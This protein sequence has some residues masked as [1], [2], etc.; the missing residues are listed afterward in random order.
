MN[1]SDSQS[2]VPCV[3]DSQPSVPRVVPCVADSQPSVPRVTGAV[4][5]L[6]SG[7]VVSYF[8]RHATKTHKN[9]TKCEY[10]LDADLTPEGE[11]EARE[12]AEELKRAGVKI[13]A[14]A[15]SPYLR[16]RRTAVI[17]AEVLGVEKVTVNNLLAECLCRQK[18]V[19]KC[20][21]RESTFEYFTPRIETTKQY[22]TRMFRLMKSAS[23]QKRTV[24]YVTHGYNIYTLSLRQM[25]KQESIPVARHDARD[26][27]NIAPG[28]YVELYF[29]R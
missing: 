7:G 2:V 28:A 14:V 13:D 21:V 9:N 10:R 3:A 6:H 8:A 25:K 1:T 17:Y 22:K 4:A 24:L 20:D 11:R 19:N 26:P 15:S 5:A 23:R 18:Y 29:A 16:A 12:Y 27:T